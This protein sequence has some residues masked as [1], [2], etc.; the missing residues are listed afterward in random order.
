[1]YNLCTVK[2]S[3]IKVLDSILQPYLC[4]ITNIMKRKDR[5]Y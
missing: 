1:M 3:I 2:S 5:S 4:T